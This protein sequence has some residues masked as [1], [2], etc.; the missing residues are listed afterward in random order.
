MITA[1][2][3]EAMFKY[4]TDAAYRAKIEL[5][6]GKTLVCFCK[7]KPCHGDVYLEMLGEDAPS[8]KL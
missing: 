4:E 3:V 5:L 7:P 6:R 2:R 8:E 1:F